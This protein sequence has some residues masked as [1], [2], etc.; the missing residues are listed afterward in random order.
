MPAL[1]TLEIVIGVLIAICQS[2]YQNISISTYSNNLTKYRLPLILAHVKFF[3][4]QAK[5]SDLN[6]D[7]TKGQSKIQGQSKP[8]PVTPGAN[9][10]GVRNGRE[11]TV[12]AAQIE[13]VEKKWL[14]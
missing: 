7:F 4:F 12:R 1:S 9:L 13:F 5:N 6:P 11:I 2:L 10:G 14:C 8:D 3:R